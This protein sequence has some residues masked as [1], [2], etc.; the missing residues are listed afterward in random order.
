MILHSILTYLVFIKFHSFSNKK[1]NKSKIYI[2]YHD[3]EYKF[4]IYLI[5]CEGIVE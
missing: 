1:K 2:I 4:L 5:S 3:H